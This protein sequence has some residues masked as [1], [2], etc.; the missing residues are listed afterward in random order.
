MATILKQSEIDALLDG[1]DI[2]EPEVDIEIGIV[3]LTG[4][5]KDELQEVKLGSQGFIVL[6]R[7]GYKQSRIVK[8]ITIIAL[9]KSKEIVIALDDNF[10]PI[11]VKAE[12]LSPGFYKTRDRI[13][14]VEIKEI[15]DEISESLE[16]NIGIT[17]N[18][19]VVSIKS[20][21]KEFPEIW[22]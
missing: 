8:H 3:Y 2:E 1:C 17:F 13:E 9:N 22:L 19:L 12:E 21:K 4:T 7:K 18:D 14:A 11:K 10:D 16:K 6:N 15:F 20:A 5:T